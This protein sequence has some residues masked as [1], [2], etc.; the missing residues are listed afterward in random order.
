MTVKSAGADSDVEYMKE[1]LRQAK[2]GLGRTSPNPAVGAVVVHEE[3][4][5]AKGFHRKAG[6]PHAEVE[7][8]EKLGGR[9]DGC[10][11]YVTLEPCNHYGKTPPCT[12][13]ILKSGIRRVVVGMK[14]PN[15]HV[16]GDGCAR[17]AES[18]LEVKAGVLDR[19]CRRLN[20]S[21]IKFVVEK[22]P[23][24]MAKSA[25]TLDG[26]TAT[27]TGDAC[28]ITNEESR[29]YVHRL[30]D[31]VDAVMVGVGTVVADDPMLTTRLRG[32]TGK[33]P[34]RIVVDTSLRTP[35]GAKVLNSRS[36]A[37]T[38]FVVGS[39]SAARHI[40]GFPEDKVTAIVCPTRSGRIDLAVLMDIL[41]RMSLTSLLVEG[42]A[43]IMGSMIRRDLIDKFYIF[44]APKILG[45]NDGIPLASGPGGK[46]IQSCLTLRDLEFRRFREDMLV[47]GYPDK[48][49]GKTEG[50]SGAEP[51]PDV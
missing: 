12:E 38:I 42:G 5:I 13:A 19:E 3:K 29:R 6:L 39:E 45:G 27:A 37:P 31:R 18:G 15:P 44:K 49:T 47:V 40:K 33:D 30:R 23:F 34:L 32:G 11:L 26:W 35:P 21:F 14:D 41:G 1:A 7:A 17:L 2:R 10:T 8:L 43:R 46:T 48:L 25:M 22:R 24:V 51:A 20:E 36:A 50:V 4:V 9:A 28:W 16:S